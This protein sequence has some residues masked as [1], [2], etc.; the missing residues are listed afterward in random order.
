MYHKFPLPHNLT[1]GQIVEV[2]RGYN[3]DTRKYNTEEFKFVKVTRKGFN[4]VSLTS[5][6]CIS[7]RSHFYAKKYR[8][9]DIPHNLTTVIVGVPPWVSDK[10][11]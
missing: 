5:H 1:L 3:S 8:N 4:L 6:K 11:M 9:K 2:R 7:P 10:I